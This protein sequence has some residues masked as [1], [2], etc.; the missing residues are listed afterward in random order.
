MSTTRFITIEGFGYSGA[1]PYEYLESVIAHCRKILTVC[2]S[3]VSLAAG[4]VAC[5]CQHTSRLSLTSCCQHLHGTHGLQDRTFRASDGCSI[6]GD[7]LF[8]TGSLISTEKTSIICQNLA[9]QREAARQ[10]TPTHFHVLLDY[11][12]RQNVLHKCFTENFD[13]LEGKLTPSL[14]TEATGPAV[15]QILGSND[16]LRC[17]D[18]QHV[19]PCEEYR[20]SLLKG[21][22][23]PCP[24]CCSDSGERNL[25][26]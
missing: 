24:K 21:V 4:V 3:G 10:A 6:Q 18:C 25:H 14:L 9:E 22:D 8:V 1:Y 19:F 13:G 26:P 7:K 2:G 16:H 23:V 15:I 20:T 11:M 5:L 17:E 12:Y